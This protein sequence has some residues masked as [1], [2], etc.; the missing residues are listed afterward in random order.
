MVSIRLLA[1]SL[2]VLVLAVLAAAVQTVRLADCMADADTAKV[3]A[4]EKLQQQTV[5]ATEAKEKLDELTAQSEVAAAASADALNR[6]RNALRKHAAATA[7]KGADAASAGGVVL[8]QGAQKPGRVEQPPEPVAVELLGACAASYQE[9]GVD[10]DTIRNRLIALQ[11]F[12]KGLY[13]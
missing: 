2:A 5:R 3:L 13:K 1:I 4:K 12:V 8:G 6:L 9:L 10:A 7:A 11:K